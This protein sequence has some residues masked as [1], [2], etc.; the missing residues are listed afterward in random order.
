MAIFS[1]LAL[2]AAG[3]AMASTHH[4]F[5]VA[6]GGEE[7]LLNNAVRYGRYFVT[8]ML[9]TGYVMFRPIANM[10]KNPL[11][12]L[13][14]V[15]LIVGAVYGTKITIEGMLGVSDMVDYQSNGFM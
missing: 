12:G 8:V 15:G 10:F 13:L 1:L 14:A 3:D 4:L 9:G 11:T 7:S 5:D 6:E 2:S